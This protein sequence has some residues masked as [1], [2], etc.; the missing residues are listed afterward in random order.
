MAQREAAFQGL[1]RE[2]VRESTL[3][4]KYKRRG[5]KIE[6]GSTDKLAEIIISATQ[7]YNDL[8][9]SV[10]AVIKTLIDGFA[11]FS[12]NAKERNDAAKALAEELNKLY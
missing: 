9:N 8:I 2:S 7:E 4:I 1:L 12:A 5:P 3:L 11:L 10:E 6:D